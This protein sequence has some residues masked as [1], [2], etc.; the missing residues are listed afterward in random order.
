MKTAAI[1][2]L[3][4]FIF[5]LSGCGCKNESPSVILKNSGSAKASIQIK[6][7]NGN[8]ENINNVDPGW[9]SEERTFAAGSIEFTVTIQGV[10][11]PVVYA[12]TVDDC[13]DYVVSINPDNTVTS[14]S[15]ERD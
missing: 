8:T 6:T 15:D 7:S 5:I 10:A 3:S 12:L 4:T 1:L 2:V 14:S 9:Q 13:A 11:E